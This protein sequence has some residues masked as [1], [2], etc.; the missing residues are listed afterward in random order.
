MYEFGILKIIYY[1]NKLTSK[2]VQPFIL[3][4]FSYT[5]KKLLDPFNYLTF[6]LM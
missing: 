2:N 1:V 4:K 3:S 5:S 6:S